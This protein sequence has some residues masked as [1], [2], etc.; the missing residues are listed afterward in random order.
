MNLS[1]HLLAS[2][3]LATI[4]WPFIGIHALWAV[5]GGFLID[6]DHWLL[7]VYRTGSFSIRRSYNHYIEEGKRKDYERDTLH[8]FH[9]VEFLMLMIVA[10]AVSYVSQLAILFY[11]FAVTFAGMVLH[12][13]LDVISLS[14][15]G[16]M[17]ARA[18]SWIRW[19][20]RH[21]DERKH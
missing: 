20:S 4:F 13:L 21:A 1:V 8:V 19:R 15:E 7:S 12:I 3:A 9:T 11:M 17:D 5:V 18:I 10:A 14:Y 2:A 16:R 6:F